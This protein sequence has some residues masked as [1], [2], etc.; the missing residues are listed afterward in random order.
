MG[1]ENGN[2]RAA[3]RVDRPEAGGPDVLGPARSGRRFVVGAIL[4]V[5]IAW[6]GLYVVFRSWRAGY[7]E[8]IAR[9]KAVLPTAVDGLVGVR[10]P[11]VPEAEWREM[12]AV[13]TAT[14]DITDER[15]QEFIL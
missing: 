2:G 3:R 1:L 14:G 6:A 11:D 10:P 4:G 15:R 5:L 13:L 8:R 9:A 12:I 7:R